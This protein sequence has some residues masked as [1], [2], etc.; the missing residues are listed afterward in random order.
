MHRL[1]QKIDVVVYKI[2]VRDSVEERILA[3]QERKR[4]LADQA[5]EGGGRKGAGKL[6]MAEIMQ[7]FRRDAE[8]G[9]GAEERRGSGGGGSAEGGGV[10]ERARKVEGRR[11]VEEHPVYGRR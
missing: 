3:L 7:L 2:T 1:T 10:L 4:A 8:E 9:P 6:G 5:I 11:R